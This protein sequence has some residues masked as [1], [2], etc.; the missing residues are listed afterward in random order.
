MPETIRK[1]IPMKTN[2][3]RIPFLHGWAAAHQL[4]ADEF[5]QSLEEGREPEAVEKIRAQAAALDQSEHERL[6]ALW[7]ELQEIPQRADYPFVEPNDLESIRSERA[8]PTP[9]VPI[10]YGD[11]VL[12]DR[13]HGAWLGRCIG[14]ALGKPVEGM[15]QPRPLRSKRAQPPVRRPRASRSRLWK[16]M[17]T[18]A[19]PSSRNG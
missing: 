6:A 4:L 14:C 7:Y 3:P 9:A 19:T 17:T 5:Q 2:F 11:D 10:P 8:Q 12:F 15:M 18:S 1:V 13:M 16:A